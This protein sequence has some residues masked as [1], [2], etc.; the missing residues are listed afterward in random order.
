MIDVNTSVVNY[1]HP[2]EVVIAMKN[3]RIPKGLSMKIHLDSTFQRTFNIKGPMGKGIKLE[4]TGVHMA[5]TAGT[6]VL[7]FMDIVAFILRVNLGIGEI[8]EH[9]FHDDFKFILYSTFSRK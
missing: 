8:D 4:K 1:R 7:V 5:Y 6:G 3:F 9:P 2:L